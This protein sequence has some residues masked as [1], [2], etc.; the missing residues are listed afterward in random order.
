MRTCDNPDTEHPG[1]PCEHPDPVL[2][3]TAAAGKLLGV[4]PSSVRELV[5][6][7]AI[8]G[9]RIGRLLKVDNDS[10]HGYLERAQVTR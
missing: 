4:G 5:R 6:S 8:T 2:I 7:G 3:S 1:F 9:Y 10:V